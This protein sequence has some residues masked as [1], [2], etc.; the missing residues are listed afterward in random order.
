MTKREKINL[1]KERVIALKPSLIEIKEWRSK[2][3]RK[4]PEYNTIYGG[5]LIN[6]LLFGRTTD[7]V[8]IDR[9]EELIEE[10]KTVKV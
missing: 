2:L 6:N 3:I 1:L 7:E 9:L 10:S 5:N 4:Y 8:L